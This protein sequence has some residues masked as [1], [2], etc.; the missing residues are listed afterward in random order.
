MPTTEN[1]S[2][3]EGQGKR[4]TTTSSLTPSPDSSLEN[5][6]DRKDEGAMGTA[7]TSP[8]PPFPV[9]MNAYGQWGKLKSFNLCGAT[10]QDRLCHVDIHTGYSGKTPL[11][12]RPGVVLHYGMSSKAP[13]LAAAGYDSQWSASIL[14]FNSES[15]I[16]MPSLLPATARTSNF[17]TEKMPAFVRGGQVVFS[18]SI[19]VSHGKEPR[20]EKFEWRKFAKDVDETAKEGGFKLVRLP[21]PRSSTKLADDTD[22]DAGSEVLALLAWRQLFPKF[23]HAFTLQLLGRG[24]SGEL[25]ER[26]SLMVVITALRLWALRVAGKTKKGVIAAGQKADGN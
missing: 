26:W 2:N 24:Q 4:L 13:I 15:V 7:I 20:R 22:A 25:G 11:G 10:E 1:D 8:H 9:V 19:E 12:T 6:A 5:L 3:V 16:L 23:K 17:V 18:F 14:S 21:S